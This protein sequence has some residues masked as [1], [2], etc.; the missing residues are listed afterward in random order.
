MEVVGLIASIAGIISFI[1]SCIELYKRIRSKFKKIPE[2][3]SRIIRELKAAQLLMRRA[4]QVMQQ[5]FAYE[6]ILDVNSALTACERHVRKL[7]LTAE[8]VEDHRAQ[9]KTFPEHTVPELE[10]QR[11]ELAEGVLK[12]SSDLRLLE[13]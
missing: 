7:S 5:S 6:A 11:E 12:L 3:I 2:I 4:S 13:W 8:R 9:H 1:I 10:K